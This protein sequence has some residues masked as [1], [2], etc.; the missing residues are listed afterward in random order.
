MCWVSKHLDPDV[1]PQ[2]GLKDIGGDGQVEGLQLRLDD[3]V[4]TDA[5]LRLFVSACGP[6]QQLD[7]QVHVQPRRHLQTDVTMTTDRLETAGGGGAEPTGPG[8]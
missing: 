2:R 7:L 8:V 1:D 3:Q 6:G 5:G 4:V